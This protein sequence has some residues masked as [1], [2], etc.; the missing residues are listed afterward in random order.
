VAVFVR[1]GVMQMVRPQ[2]IATACVKQM[3]IALVETENVDTLCSLPW[4]PQEFV[5][6]W[7][8]LQVK[9][10]ASS[11]K[12][13][14]VSYFLVLF[15]LATRKQRHRLAAAAMYSRYRVENQ[16]G[17][18]AVKSLSTALASLSL[19]PP[20]QQYFLDNDWRL[21]SET[22]HAIT[23]IDDVRREVMKAKVSPSTALVFVKKQ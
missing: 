23:S 21:D 8:T 16:Q 17:A 19:L 13:D 7:E 11:D 20:S 14:A 2:E 9:A 5:T 12:D 1:D 6:L 22:P 10:H 18:A 3:A 4:S 15:T